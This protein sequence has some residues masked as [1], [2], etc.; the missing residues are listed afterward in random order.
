M[1]GESEASKYDEEYIDSQIENINAKVKEKKEE[2][3]DDKWIG[4]M[5]LILIW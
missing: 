1:S 2:K 5:N 3:I 4:F